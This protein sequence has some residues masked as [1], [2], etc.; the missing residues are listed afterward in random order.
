MRIEKTITLQ[1]VDE[2]ETT[3]KKPYLSI[4]DTKGERYTSWVTKLFPLLTK[5]ATLTVFVEPSGNFNNIVDVVSDE[6][7]IEPDYDQQPRKP[8]PDVIKPTTADQLM[9]D[10]TRHWPRGATPLDE[11]QELKELLNKAWYNPTAK[12]LN[13]PPHPLRGQLDRM[14]LLLK[15]IYESLIPPLN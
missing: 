10:I 8:F 2:K 7:G 6:L 3:A 1:Y 11:N 15:A 9:K 4:K 12:G 5:G 14:E 13:I